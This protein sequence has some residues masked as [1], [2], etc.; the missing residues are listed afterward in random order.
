MRVSWAFRVVRAVIPERLNAPGKL[1][2][3]IARLIGCFLIV[4]IRSGFD[5]LSDTP[6]RLIPVVS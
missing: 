5:K 3:L 6:R 4:E 1:E 2:K